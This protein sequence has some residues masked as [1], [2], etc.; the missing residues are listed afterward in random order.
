MDARPSL[1][2]NSHAARELAVARRGGRGH[3]RGNGADRR[4]RKRERGAGG[5]NARSWGQGTRRGR[6]RRRLRDRQ[7]RRELAWP[8]GRAGVVAWRPRPQR[9]P[10]RPCGRQVRTG[11]VSR[12]TRGATAPLP[13]GRDGSSAPVLV[14]RNEGKVALHIKN[15]AIRTTE[16]EL[17]EYF[18]AR[19]KVSA[20]AP[21][22]RLRTRAA[23]MRRAVPLTVNVAA[24]V[25]ARRA[26]ERRWS[27][28][29]SSWIRRQARAAVMDSWTWPPKRTPSSRSKP[30]APSSTA[31]SLASSG[32]ATGSR[33][34]E[35]SVGSSDVGGGGPAATGQ[36][37]AR[38]FAHAGCVQRGSA[39]YV[40]LVW[41]RA[42]GHVWA[43]QQCGATHPRRPLG[44]TVCVRWADSRSANVASRPRRRRRPRA[45]AGA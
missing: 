42:N 31:A 32:C 45:R 3:H 1:P 44:E 29:L 34:R 33:R 25:H 30:T 38:A 35:T 4:D 14:S 18:G 2:R 28:Q 24:L 21:R 23:R 11:L 9:A 27:A 40:S 8:R 12:L 37:G 43:V 39:R 10:V 41:M 15:L 7:H 6:A 13:C 20:A 16:K 5:A 26:R 22:Q 19:A 36:T 17:Y